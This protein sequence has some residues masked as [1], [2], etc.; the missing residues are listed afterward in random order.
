MGVAGG[1]KGGGVCALRTG[2]RLGELFALTWDD[3][4]FVNSKILVRRN[5]THGKL[6]PPKSGKERKVP[7]SPEL[8][9][10]LRGARHLKSDLVFCR[11][12]GTYLSYE[13]LRSAFKR[14][15]RS[16]G[17]P[18][19]TPHGMRH[20]FASQLVMASAPLKVV[21]E[22]L[23]HA[24]I[25]MTMRYAHVAPGVTDDYVARLDGRV[26]SAGHKRGVGDSLARESQL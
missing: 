14:T 5:W 15:Q 1:K 11:E 25:N 22:L 2:L 16:A 21:Q 20:S 3:V 23:G 13:N 18:R 26:P 17:L 8:A 19:N 6:V 9:R 10:E 24:D 4:D 12:D 7:M